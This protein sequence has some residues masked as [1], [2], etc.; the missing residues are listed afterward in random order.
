MIKALLR[1]RKNELRK[2]TIWTWNNRCG[3]TF[4]DD[5]FRS[6]F[7]RSFMQ[8]QHHNITSDKWSD[9]NNER[10]YHVKQTVENRRS[11]KMGDVAT[12]LFVHFNFIIQLRSIVFIPEIN[13]HCI[14][15]QIYALFIEFYYALFL[16]F[17]DMHLYN[18]MICTFCTFW[19]QWRS[20]LFITWLCWSAVRN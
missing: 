7:L 17:K 5:I 1:W 15:S 3:L 6:D 20:V 9:Q 14:L 2:I 18:T 16:F 10:F 4:K 8:F 19:K 12:L 13:R 11:S